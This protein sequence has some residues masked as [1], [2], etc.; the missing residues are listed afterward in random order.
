M[1]QEKVQDAA[2]DERSAQEH[3]YSEILN[4]S[5]P[6][7]NKKGTYSYDHRNDTADVHCLFHS[8]V[9]IRGVSRFNLVAPLPG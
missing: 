6:R 5:K 1:A 7:T 4:H 3:I 2:V 9:H 8:D